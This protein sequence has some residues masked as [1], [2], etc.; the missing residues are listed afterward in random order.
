MFSRVANS[1][2]AFHKSHGGTVF[3]LCRFENLRYKEIAK[4]LGIS[5]NTVQNHMVIAMRQLSGQLDRLRE[6][7]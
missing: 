5:K 7:M 6:M 3:R 4:V 2:G 1:H